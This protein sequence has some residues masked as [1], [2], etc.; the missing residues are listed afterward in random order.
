MGTGELMST[1][2]LQAVLAGDV[3]NDD[4]DLPTKEE[5]KVKKIC[6]CINRKA[7][8]KRCGC[9]KSFL[10]QPEEDLM[11]PNFSD[12][13][14]SSG[15]SERE[16]D[17]VN[18]IDG[19][20]PYVAFNRLE[21]NDQVDRLFFMWQL[22]Y[23]KLRGSVYLVQAFTALHNSL[24]VKGTTKTWKHDK[25]ERDDQVP[26]WYVIMPNWT[27][28]KIWSAI[29]QMILIYTA[30]YVPFK[31]SFIPPGQ[32]VPFWDTIDS[33]VDFLFITDLVVNFISAFERRDGSYETRPRLI[34]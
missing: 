30:I 14:F 26:E 13:D 28:K 18:Y 19:R 4:L 16:E 12:E 24:Y 5:L 7:L 34:A 25:E 23:R 8:L 22:L 3:S 31:L 32:D 33:I 15:E 1:L 10:K 27:F 29:I 6:C 17:M 11:G 20:K 9:L 21:Q 2:K